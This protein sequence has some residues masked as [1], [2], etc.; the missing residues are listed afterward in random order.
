MLLND[1][2]LHLASN[3]EWFVWAEDKQCRSNNAQIR[4]QDPPLTSLKF[5]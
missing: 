4:K 2:I 5:S 1:S 3:A